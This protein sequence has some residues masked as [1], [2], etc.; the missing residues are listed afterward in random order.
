[1]PTYNIVPLSRDNY[2]VWRMQ[3]QSVLQLKRLWA[4]VKD[5][6]LT[7]D[8]QEANDDALAYLRLSVKE[9]QAKYLRDVTSAHEAWN[10]LEKVHRKT[11]PAYELKLY[12]QLG[13]KCNSTSEL[14]EHMERFFTTADN[15]ASVGSSIS[16]NVLVYMLLDSLPTSFVNFEVAITT[17]ET[18]PDLSEL[19]VKIEEELDRQLKHED[20]KIGGDA[21]TA[22]EQAWL[23]RKPWQ[24]KYNGPT[25]K[26][27]CYKCNQFGHFAAECPTNN[28]SRHGFLVLS[29]YGN[30]G[31]S[32]D[33]VI[34]SGST[35][36]FV[37]S[38]SLIARN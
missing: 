34:D 9:C 7:K 8:N 15:M 19:R 27:R 4:V 23:A 36:H 33:W 22:S 11:G 38:E 20:V 13:Q 35:N 16:E 10:K 32:N 24:R 37:R 26:G 29:A 14:K 25:K 5:G 12:R 28:G 2:E 18:L 31:S 3:V 21:E 1:M 6:K 17:R 30:A